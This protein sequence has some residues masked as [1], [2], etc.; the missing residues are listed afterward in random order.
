MT[1]RSV[2]RCIG[3]IRELSDMRTHLG[4]SV[5]LVLLLKDFGEDYL[6]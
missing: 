1:F 2:I 4:A 3:K 5:S 6:K